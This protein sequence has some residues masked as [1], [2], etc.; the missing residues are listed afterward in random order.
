[1]LFFY[2][3]KY[4]TGFITDEEI[5]KFLTLIKIK[6]KILERERILEIK[7]IQTK[8]IY[9][10]IVEQIVNL[11]C[12]GSLS[13]GDK[14]PP[15]RILAEMFQVSRASLREALSVM[16]ILGMIEIRPGEGSFVSNLNM[17]PFISLLFPLFLKEEN[18]E[19]DLLDLREILE[20]SSIRFSVLALQEE[21]PV[22][23]KLE[24]IVKKM[25]NSGVE[26]TPE[27]FSRY[28]IE[29]HSC[30]LSLYK[31]Q[32]ITKVL[33]YI[34]FIF[35]K[36]IAISHAKFFS[37]EEVVENLLIQHRDIYYA[38]K[39]RDADLAA[40][41]MN[42]HLNYVKTEFLKLQK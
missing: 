3:R 17:E 14:L 39:N 42:I 9:K 33:D 24:S 6:D 41:K 26:T 5:V 19:K 10:N 12:E 13:A 22:L 21:E 2:R 20:V 38:I 4:K 36:S 37:N 40:E 8:K 30:I 7:S 11:I 29:F 34:N 25:E 31:N 35:K 16:E 1:M 27:M 32:I 23:K 18:I 28:D 15:E